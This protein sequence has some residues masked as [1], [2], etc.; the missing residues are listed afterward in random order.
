MMNVVPPRCRLPGSLVMKPRCANDVPLNERPP[1]SH[2]SPTSVC[3]MNASWRLQYSA[4]FGQAGRARREDDRDRSVGIVGERRGRGRRRRAASASIVRGVVDRRACGSGDARARRRARA[5]REPVVHAGG[6]RA[7]L[8]RR[9][10]RE[11]VLD[12][13]R[14]HERDDVAFADALAARARRRPRRRCD[15]CRRRRAASRAR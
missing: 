15:R 5:G 11:Q 9:A 2:A 6:D 14:Q 10:V 7:E 12:A 8:G 1:L 4:P 3:V 13:R